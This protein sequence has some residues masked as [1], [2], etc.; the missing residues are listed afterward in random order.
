MRCRGTSILGGTVLMMAVGCRGHRPSSLP[1]P[2]YE[3]PVLPE[4]EPPEGSEDDA[5]FAD[6]TQ[7]EGEWVVDEDAEDESEVNDAAENGRV[8]SGP[9]QPPE[10]QD[11]SGPHD[12]EEP[13]AESVE[14]DPP[15]HDGGENGLK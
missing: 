14:P 4:W 2:T 13:G 3:R 5:P 9:D 7:M 1:P 12:S 10:E 15:A 11:E 6:L 8:D